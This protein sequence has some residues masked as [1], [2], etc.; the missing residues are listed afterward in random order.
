MIILF[1]LLT[2]VLI[3]CWCSVVPEHI[4]EGRTFRGTIRE[5]AES[6]DEV[7]LDR[8]LMVNSG[9]QSASQ[10]GELYNSIYLYPH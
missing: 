5:D 6:G 3:C 7:E 1:S 10:E 9:D 4:G 2:M 8:E